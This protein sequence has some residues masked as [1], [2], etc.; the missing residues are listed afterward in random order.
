MRDRDLENNEKGF[1][2][3]DMLWTLK[4]KSFFKQVI[5]ILRDRFISYLEV[6]QYSFYHKDDLQTMKEYL[7]L[8]MSHLN[9]GSIF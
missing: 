6:W 7:E 9:V 2:F 5:E 8:Y 3:E 1:N 4:D